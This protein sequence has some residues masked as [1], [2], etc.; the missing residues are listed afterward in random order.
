MITIRCQRTGCK[1][2]SQEISEG[3]KS[4]A[5]TFLRWHIEDGS[6]S[7]PLSAAPATTK[8][9][10]ATTKMT[11]IRCQ[12]TG[13]KW[14][15][16]E[17]T[18]SYKLAYASTLLRWHIEDGLCSSPLSAAPATAKSAPTTT[19][20]PQDQKPQPSSSEMSSATA[21]LPSPSPTTAIAAPASM[22]STTAAQQ[23]SA[24]LCHSQSR[25]QTRSSENTSQLLLPHPPGNTAGSGSLPDTSTK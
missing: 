2:V 18:E 4:Y 9:A 24:S 11:T 12:R 1:W 5:S 19:T 10:P 15:S 7:S 21:Q 6:C 8:L 22:L 3:F 20:A 25:S 16:E 13:C 17:I 23:T 14:V